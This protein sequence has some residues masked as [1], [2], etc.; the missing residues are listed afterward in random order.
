MQILYLCGLV[1]SAVHE[2]VYVIVFM[3]G[4]ERLTLH[5]TV[6]HNFC[7]VMKDLQYISHG[8]LQVL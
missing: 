1:S 2:A 8:A 6:C 4:K 3:K 7:L 5:D